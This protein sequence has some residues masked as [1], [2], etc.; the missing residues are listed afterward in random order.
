MRI[1]DQALLAE[2]RAAPRCS[3]CG[4]ATPDGCQPHHLWARGMGGAGRLDVRCNLIALCARC[5][6]EVHD[7]HIL[8][9]DLLAVVAVRED[10]RQDQI[11]AEIHRLR[12]A[13][14]REA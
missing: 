4:Q 8:R 1:I 14:W 9:I 11:E 3:W 13:P 5:H 10:L 2:F 12:R 7:G 6:R